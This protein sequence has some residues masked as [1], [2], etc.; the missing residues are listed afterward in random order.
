MKIVRTIRMTKEEHE[1]I[2]NFLHIIFADDE[3]NSYS[4]DDIYE[5]IM[6]KDN[7]HRKIFNIEHTDEE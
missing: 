6:A 3:L 5:D 1:V 4:R 2:K 7:S